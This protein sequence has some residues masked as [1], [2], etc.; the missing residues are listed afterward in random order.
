MFVRDNFV[1]GD[2]HGG[3]ILQAG[4]PEPGAGWSGLGR[5]WWWL[6][7]GRGHMAVIDAGL[8]TR[9]APEQVAPAAPRAPS[10]RAAPRRDTW[11]QMRGHVPLFAWSRA[12][13]SAASLMLGA[14]VRGVSAAIR[15]GARRPP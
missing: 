14:R 1:H 2:L 12:I 11:Q 6:W 9:V 10:G 13:I 3:N 7:C 4:P 5:W 15:G 8:V